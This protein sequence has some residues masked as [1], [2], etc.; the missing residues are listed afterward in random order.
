MLYVHSLNF[1]SGQTT[2]ERFAR[3]AP[4]SVSS[5]GAGLSNKS[6]SFL[7]SHDRDSVV[8]SSKRSI[9]EDDNDD[10]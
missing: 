8:G 7:I 4:S 6:D 3:K 2:N 10:R 5:S 1:A 9:V